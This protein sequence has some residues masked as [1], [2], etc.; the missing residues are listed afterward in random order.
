MEISGSY[1]TQVTALKQEARLCSFARQQAALFGATLQSL[2]NVSDS[3]AVCSGSAAA[4]RHQAGYKPDE[5]KKAPESEPCR[6]RG[7]LGP[8]PLGLKLLQG[9][10][11]LTPA[12]EEPSGQDA[13]AAMFSLLGGM[14]N[15]ALNREAL[16]SP[17]SEALLNVK[18]LLKIMS[19]S[20]AQGAFT[21]L[22]QQ[23][24]NPGTQETIPYLPFM[25]LTVQRLNELKSLYLRRRLREQTD[26]R[27]KQNKNKEK[28]Q[29]FCLY[30]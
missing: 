4:A 21:P 18:L 27:R 17:E 13:A 28:N 26:R 25:L 1:L 23:N 12:A 16:P 8:E 15:A 3:Q 2:N 11:A 20:F 19:G 22:S 14:Q 10:C 6:I 24:L 9:S 7:D 30:F 5:K 29:T